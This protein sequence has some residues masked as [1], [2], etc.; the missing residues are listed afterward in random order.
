MMTTRN[1]PG[2]RPLPAASTAGYSLIELLVVLGIIAL[3]GS[4]ATPQ[5]L[6]YLGS[7]RVDAATTQIRNLSSAMELFYLDAGRYPTDE[8]GLAA[9][10]VAPLSGVRWNG[11]YLRGANELKDPWGNAYVYASLPDKDGFSIRSL[12]RDG[13]PGGEGQDGDLSN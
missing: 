6:G 12:G 5:I 4:I 8:E 9:L 11:P 2:P 13:K 10:A 1:R 3:I 7:A